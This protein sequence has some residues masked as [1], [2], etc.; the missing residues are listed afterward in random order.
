MLVSNEFK[1][2]HRNCIEPCIEIPFISY[3]AVILQ[4][5]KSFN[6]MVQFNTIKQIKLFRNQI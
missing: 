5:S 6:L 4:Y 3:Y 2:G 1:L